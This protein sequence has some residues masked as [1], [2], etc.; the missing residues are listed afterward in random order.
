MAPLQLP[1]FDGFL[2]LASTANKALK[3]VKTA[4]ITHRIE[5]YALL[6]ETDE[7]EKEVIFNLNTIRALKD[8][9]A[10]LRNYVATLKVLLD[11]ST[12]DGQALREFAACIDALNAE[13]LMAAAADDGIRFRA[14]ITKMERLYAGSQAQLEELAL[15]SQ[16]DQAARA[17]AV[18]RS[19]ELEERL[20]AAEAGR[21]TAEAARAV[22][23]AALAAEAPVAAILAELLRTSDASLAA[24]EARA[25]KLQAEVS[26]LQRR[27]AAKEEED[28]GDALFRE[29]DEAR[30]AGLADAAR[31]AADGARAPRAACP[32]HT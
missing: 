30:E 11:A 16:A 22:A 5:K 14:Y 20:Q 25:A 24:A 17:A 2:V 31:E 29:C 26:A 28:D 12:A 19:T 23:E 1:H 6:Q 18:Q 3:E 21:A 10:G 4:F 8:Q 13:V 15:K 9:L 27:A 32:G 7:L